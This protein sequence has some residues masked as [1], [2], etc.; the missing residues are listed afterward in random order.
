MSDRRSFEAPRFVALNPGTWVEFAPEEQETESHFIPRDRAP[1]FF[2]AKK[3]LFFDARCSKLAKDIPLAIISSDGVVIRLLALN[4]MPLSGKSSTLKIV[5]RLLENQISTDPTKSPWKHVFYFRQASEF[6]GTDQT[7]L[8]PPCLIILDQFRAEESDLVRKVVLLA[9]QAPEYYFL[10]C[11][12]ANY[13]PAVS[14]GAVFQAT[15]LPFEPFMSWEDFYRFHSGRTLAAAEI[16]RPPDPRPDAQWFSFVPGTALPFDPMTCQLSATGFAG[17]SSVPPAPSQII[18]PSPEVPVNELFLYTN[19]IIGLAQC[20]Q[21]VPAGRSFFSMRVA[22]DIYKSMMEF[23]RRPEQPRY[24]RRAN[25]EWLVAKRAITLKAPAWAQECDLRF[26]VPVPAGPGL[27]DRVHYRLGCPFYAQLYM[28]VLDDLPIPPNE[29]LA[30]ASALDSWSGYRDIQGRICERAVISQPDKLYKVPADLVLPSSSPEDARALSLEPFL[31][32]LGAGQVQLPLPPFLHLVP[33]DPSYPNIDLMRIYNLSGAPGVS[34]GGPATAAA[35]AAPATPRVALIVDQITVSR[36]RDHQKSLEWL[37]SP[38]CAV[39]CR[40]IEAA[41]HCPPA[42]KVFVFIT[43]Q[44]PGTK[45]AV[46]AELAQRIRE[47][48]WDVWWTSLWPFISSPSVDTPVAAPFRLTI[49]GRPKALDGI[50]AAHDKDD[51]EALAKFTVERLRDF[52]EGEGIAVSD[53]AVK[54]EVIDAI[55]D[56][57]DAFTL[58]AIATRMAK[59]KTGAEEAAGGHQQPRGSRRAREREASPVEHKTRTRGRSETEEEKEETEAD[60]DEKKKTEEEEKKKK[61]K[62]EEEEVV[63]VE[64]EKEKE[65]EE[66]EAEEIEA[67]CSKGSRALGKFTIRL[68]SAYTVARR[69]DPP[70]PRSIRK[71]DLITRIMEWWKNKDA[72]A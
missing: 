60:D 57:G 38:A 22:A 8:E 41:Y 9:S 17:S 14:M 49:S 63:V 3:R 6:M 11:S 44:P 1:A 12:S 67:A 65:K 51:R 39:V 19:G 7:I 34:D 47:N 35:C 53:A 21:S 46:R 33:L 16:P 26:L 13:R 40:G 50:A 28:K 45:L 59:P 15:D 20:V 71:A 66:L 31:N 69:F 52:A 30:F 72:N 56:K 24:L 2:S 5:A 10:V 48:G 54:L 18:P 62:T 55:M 58:H 61:K 70:V 68:L 42:R 37:C 64:K 23:L 27:G 32:Q 4:G 29:V 36:F 25:I 43:L